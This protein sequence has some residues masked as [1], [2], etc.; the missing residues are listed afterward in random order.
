MTEEQEKK[1]AR[2]PPPAIGS[3]KEQYSTF[4][5][6]NG[7]TVETLDSDTVKASHSGT[8]KLEQSETRKLLRG[9]T[10]KELERTTVSQLDSEKQEKTS[11]YLSA[12]LLEKLDDLA[13]DYRKASG[14]RINRND[15]VRHLV[16]GCSLES[17]SGL[18]PLE[19]Q[20]GKQ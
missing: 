6:T 3:L 9:E 15:I 11:F 2:R 12:I 7:D 4:G 14:H 17:L 20:K 13:H 19:R 8:V 1:K 10:V 16:E 5:S 18:K